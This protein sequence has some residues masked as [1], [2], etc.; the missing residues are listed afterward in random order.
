MRHGFSLIELSIVLVILG[1]LTG[2]ILGGQ[3]LIRAAELRNLTTQFTSYQTAVRSFQV[4]Y[5]ALP[6]DMTNAT[7][8]WGAAHSTPSICKTTA[9]TGTET[10]NGDGN[11]QIQDWPTGSQEWFRAW[12]HLANAGLIEGQYTGVAGPKGGEDAIPGENVPQGKLNDGGFQLQSFINNPTWYFETAPNGITLIYGHPHD[13]SGKIGLRIMKPEEVWSID[14][15]IDDGKPSRGNFYVGKNWNCTTTDDEATAEY[16]LTNTGVQC[17][18]HYFM[19]R[20]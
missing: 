2:G 20:Y 14:T 15:K 5:H 8:F 10:C 13:S 12:Q 3:H 18:A 16:D 4:K 6:G 17:T 1:L 11:G 19:G 9:S 7:N